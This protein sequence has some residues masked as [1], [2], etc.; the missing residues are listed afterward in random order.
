MVGGPAISLIVPIV[1]AMTLD[2]VLLGVKNVTSVANIPLIHGSTIGAVRQVLPHG[3][4]EWR[5]APLAAS[6]YLLL[7]VLYGALPLGHG[8]RQYCRYARRWPV[9]AVR[10]LVR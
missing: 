10:Q 3:H 1:I 5:Y 9:G 8:G 6:R 7:L 2:E 4:S